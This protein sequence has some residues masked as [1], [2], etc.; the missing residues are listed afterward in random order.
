[1]LVI[2]RYRHQGPSASALKNYIQAG[3]QVVGFSGDAVDIEIDEDGKGTSD[4]LDEFMNDQDYT[5]EEES[6]K[7]ETTFRLLSSTGQKFDIGVDDA[8]VLV[9]TK[10]VVT[11]I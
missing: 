11:P 5:F 7:T 8:G 6:P 9:V 4:S 1:M 2:R 3:A 10:V